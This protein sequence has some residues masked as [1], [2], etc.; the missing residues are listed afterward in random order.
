[1]ISNYRAHAKVENASF[2]P[3]TNISLVS[4]LNLSLPPNNNATVFLFPVLSLPYYT[5]RTVFG[6][7][8]KTTT[9]PQ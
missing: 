7:S 2:Y 4:A 1:V 3:I 9:P 8:L 5:I 6:V